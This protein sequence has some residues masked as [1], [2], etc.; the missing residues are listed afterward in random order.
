MA[1]KPII[2]IT[3]PATA[4]N[5]M[6]VISSVRREKAAE[7]LER[8][9]AHSEATL[10]FH[11]RLVFMCLVALSPSLVLPKCSRTRRVSVM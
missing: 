8:N 6:E 3:D 11:Q 5:A 7:K 10:K 4:P 9:T 2:I 1:L